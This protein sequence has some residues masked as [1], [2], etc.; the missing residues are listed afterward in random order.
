VITS[1]IRLKIAPTLSIV[2]SQ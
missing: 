1:D 2:N